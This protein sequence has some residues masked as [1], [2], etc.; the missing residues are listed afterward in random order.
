LLLGMLRRNLPV[1]EAWQSLQRFSVHGLNDERQP[2]LSD[3]HV[4]GDHSY[5]CP[6]SMYPSSEYFSIIIFM[7][8]KILEDVSGACEYV[9]SSTRAS[10]H[11]PPANRK[12][13]QTVSGPFQP[14]I[15]PE[16][17]HAI[18]S[19]LSLVADISHSGFDSRSLVLRNC[20]SALR[21]EERRD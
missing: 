2:I 21:C 20:H 5:S 19:G 8:G 18:L 11:I 7:H 14:L 13:F 15:I 9:R 17:I 10:S 12:A 6:A 1:E 3:R 4:F 16:R